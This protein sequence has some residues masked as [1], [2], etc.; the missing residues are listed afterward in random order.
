M[1]LQIFGSSYRINHTL[2]SSSRKIL[3]EVLSKVKDESESRGIKKYYIA[4][5]IMMYAMSS[6][7]LEELGA[8]NLKKICES[9]EDIDF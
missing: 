1:I 5:V 3:R 4:F 8:D 6:A 7:I 2:A 9:S